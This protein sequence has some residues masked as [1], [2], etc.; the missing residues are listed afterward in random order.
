MAAGA[1]GTS[2]ASGAM[3]RSSGVP[4]LGEV[5]TDAELKALR[6]QGAEDLDDMLRLIPLRHVVPGELRSLRELHEGQDVS[7]IVSVVDSRTRRMKR[8]PGSILEVLVGDGTERLTLT[9]F[10]PKDHIVRWHQERLAPGTRIVVFGT[11]HFDE[12]F[13]HGA[14][15]IT[16][17]RYDLVGDSAEALAAAMRPI[18]VYS[19]R[20]RTKQ[21]T[22]R[23]A[24]SK[25]VEYAGQLSTILP[26]QVL[27]SEH[28]PTMGE[29]MRMV[30]APRTAE[31]IEEGKRHLVFEEAFVLQTIFAQRRAVDARTPAPALRAD[32]PLQ[33]LVDQRLPFTLT[34]EQIEVGEA[35]RH[36]LGRARPTNVLLQ[37]DV[38]SGKTVVALRAMLQAVD[39]GYQAVLLAPTEVLA[40][41][42][43]RTI[44]GLL[45]DLGAADHMHAHPD[46][47]TVRLLTG[48]QST[49][50]RRRTLLD[51]TSGTAGIIVG[52]HAVLT[53][54]VEFAAL[55]LA[56]IDEQH[57]FGV[58]HRRRL[59]AK[60]PKGQSPHVVV[61][62][63]TPIPRTAALATAGDLD[64]L[65]L[66]QI[67]AGRPG[68]SSYVVHEQ[69]PAWEARMWQRTA[70]EIREGR[71]AFVVC[72]RIDD[73]GDAGQ[74]DDLLAGM[75]P[76][77]L[78]GIPGF[79][80]RSVT[81]TAQRLAARPELQDARIG[82]LHGRLSSQEKQE[83]MDAM[84]AG[85]LDLLVATT[86]VEV[87]VDLP[88]AS[89]MIVLD[90]ERFGVS[91]L[92][93][94]RGRIGRGEHP[95]IAFFDTRAA[96][97]SEASEHLEKVAA[98]RDGFALA[99][100]DMQ[101]RGTGDLVGEEQSGLHR[102]LRYLDVVRDADI[103]SRARS[104]AFDLVADDAELTEHPQLAAAV[105]RRL[106]DADPN[107][108]RS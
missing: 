77:D 26:P 103:I 90:A 27:A 104:A 68:I 51:I 45:G 101:R 40:E 28:L 49:A 11:V 42:H 96:H 10:L 106:R 94:L 85:E 3:R 107:V 87:G 108:E 5:L 47:T 81:E 7:A 6:L 67:P 99:E 57:R 4:A 80:P 83:V 23:N 14:P 16:N 92:H 63:A 19:L 60:G 59:R 29:A 65:S 62:T 50:E 102:T 32:G 82:M 9:F 43:H 84:V 48:S 52:T 88:N 70:E 55:G 72:A 20:R 95:G 53:E 39:S 35:I 34:E 89:V 30:H 33:P 38:G 13:N 2:R 93:Q 75:A 21:S 36:D 22:M 18:P 66:R 56:V 15:Q 44:R 46:A 37:G 61:M 97:G 98:T 78:T 105:E 100:I 8:R 24:Y 54:S 74:T 17:P 79:D 31:E 25:A 1:D 86:M 73:S 91:Q 12:R 76:G 41:Q 64:L 69:D 71:Q 58:D